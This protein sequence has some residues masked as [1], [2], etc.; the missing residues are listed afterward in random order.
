MRAVFESCAANAEI[1]AMIVIDQPLKRKEL[2]AIRLTTPCISSRC[3][4]LSSAV[5]PPVAMTPIII[6]LR[7][8]CNAN[9]SI[10]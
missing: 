4:R 6:L 10:S 1:P 9:I 3:L 2:D 5:V 7:D 8:V